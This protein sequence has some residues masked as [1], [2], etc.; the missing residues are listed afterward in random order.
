M[1]SDF[2]EHKENILC[3]VFFTVNS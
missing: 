3:A 1:N 2:K